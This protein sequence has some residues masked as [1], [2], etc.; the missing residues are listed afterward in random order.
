MENQ[1]LIKKTGTDSTTVQ[2]LFFQH[3]KSN[4]PAH[5][6]LAEEI[7]TILDISNDSAYR[8]I[9]GE[10]PITIDEMQKLSSHYHLSVDQILNINSNSIVFTGNNITPGNFDFELYLR[11]MLESFKMIAATGQKKMYYEAKDMPIFYHFQFNELASFKYFFWMK[12]VLSDPRYAKVQYEDN[13]LGD[14]LLKWGKE[15]I[16]TYNSIPSVEIWT[17]ESVNATLHQLEYY[18]YTGVFTKKENIELLYSQ[19]EKV[20]DHIKEQAEAGEK[21]LIG[22]K[23]AGRNNYQLY[24][25]EVFLGH[26]CILVETD[27][28]LTTFVNHGTLNYITTRDKNFC[29]YSKASIENTIRKSLLISQVSEKERNRFFNIVKDKISKSKEKT[30]G[31]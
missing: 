16:K 17:E 29:E 15:I 30:L 2:Q 7:A 26:N 22:E 20:I 4:L 14:V 5:M 28:I 19:F 13:E 9:R 31:A 11:S 23:P 25:N 10:K 21:Y 12:T 24:F 3:I 27:G 6:S 8:R 18:T 1:D